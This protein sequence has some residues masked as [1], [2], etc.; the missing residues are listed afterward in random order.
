MKMKKTLAVLLSALLLLSLAACATGTIQKSEE[1]SEPSDTSKPEQKEPPVDP[2]ADLPADVEDIQWDFTYEESGWD[3]SY[4]TW[5]GWKISGALDRALEESDGTN[6]LAVLVSKEDP[7][8][9]STFV[10]KGMTEQEALD[11][12]E[13]LGYREKRYD[14]LMKEIDQRR[15]THRASYAEE[16]K[17]AFDDAE[18]VVRN[19]YV[20]LFL[21]KDELV[22][23]EIEGKENYRLSLATRYQYA[24][25]V[26][27]IF[28]E[29]TGFDVDKLEFDFDT[30]IM[31]GHSWQLTSD[32]DVI[33]V[34]HKI[35]WYYPVT[36]HSCKIEFTIQ[37]ENPLT[38]EDLMH[39]NY[40][41]IRQGSDP[42]TIV[43]TV[44]G[45]RLNLQALRDLTKRED[46]ASIV[47]HNI[48]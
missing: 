26:E 40:K 38:E 16:L 8:F 24:G 37:S 28:S 32:E 14:E 35:L 31:V 19:G 30:S 25:T 43:V 44:M 1:E 42:Q 13:G 23:L 12:R 41:S 3:N 2:Y 11:E 39:M 46:V 21:H 4:V 34:F 29:V 33:T 47:V 27:N 15:Q 20:F 9:K 48:I 36:E 5:N 22:D 6:Y 17:V 10:Y 18:P 45:D 7:D